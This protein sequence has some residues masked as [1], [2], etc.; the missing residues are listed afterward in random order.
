MLDADA[1]ASPFYCGKAAFTDLHTTDSPVST[2]SSI[3]SGCTPAALTPQQKA[4]E[5][6]FF[7]LSGCYVSPAQ[8]Q[9][10]LPPL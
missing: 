6:L 9:K 8:P 1:E 3:P 2:V 4:L 10:G 5:F 7:D